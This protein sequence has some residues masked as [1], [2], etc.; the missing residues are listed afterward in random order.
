M[1]CNCTH[2]APAPARVCAKCGAPAQ[3]TFRSVTGA[4]RPIC[5]ACLKVCNA[6]GSARA[7]AGSE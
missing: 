1:S 3:A 7:A 5:L 4:L 2:A 6:L